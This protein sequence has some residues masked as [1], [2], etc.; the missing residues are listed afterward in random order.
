MIDIFLLHEYKN[1]FNFNKDV[2]ILNKLFQ[3]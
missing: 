3:I 2:N 1:I